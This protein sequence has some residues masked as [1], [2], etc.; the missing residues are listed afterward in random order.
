MHIVGYAQYIYQYALHIDKYDLSMHIIFFYMHKLPLQ[1]AK[2]HI[3][4]NYSDIITFN[5]SKYIYYNN[6]RS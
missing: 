2:N 4:L 6:L 1:K 5:I 3:K